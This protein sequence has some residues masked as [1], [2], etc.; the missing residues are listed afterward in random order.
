M[1]EDDKAM[2]IAQAIMDKAAKKYRDENPCPECGSHDVELDI[3]YISGPRS[4]WV[5]WCNTCG[6]KRE[7]KT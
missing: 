1:N 4:G 2:K 5:E 7:T 6:W 3:L